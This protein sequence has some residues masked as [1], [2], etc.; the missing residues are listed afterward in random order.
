MFFV[1]VFIVFRCGFCNFIANRVCGQLR[2]N[3]G[4][5]KFQFL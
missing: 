4:R 1:G 5:P 2:A 3:D